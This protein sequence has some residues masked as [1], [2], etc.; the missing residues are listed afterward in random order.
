MVA[1]FAKE[2]L[3]QVVLRGQ[4]GYGKDPPGNSPDT[5]DAPKSAPGEAQLR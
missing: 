2:M 1:L 4:G 5:R 3:E